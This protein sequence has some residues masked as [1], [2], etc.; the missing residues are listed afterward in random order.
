MNYSAI[1][2]CAG[3]GKRTGLGYNKMF[4]KLNGETDYEKSVKAFLNDERCKQIIIVSKM[5]EREDFKNLLNEERMVFVNGGKE[6]QDSVFEGLKAV[7]QDYVMIH[8]GARPY[9][10]QELLDR[11]VD[12]LSS[13]DACL[14][15]V[16]CKDTIKRV[17][18]G[19][20]VNTLKREELYQ[21]QTPQ[22]FKT[23]LI[24]KAHDY[25][26][27]HQV[28][29]TDDASMVEIMGENVYV[30]EGDYDNI[31]ITT[32]EDLR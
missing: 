19:K 11:I 13:C 3:S 29:V 21:A 7:N 27:V 1:I 26:K 15:M 20:V 22:S 8:D 10:S 14:P 17:V 2:L 25:A 31:K 30:V 18:D 24:I 4:F 5:E 28:S 32:K 6:R 23:A 16:R 9:V 12:T